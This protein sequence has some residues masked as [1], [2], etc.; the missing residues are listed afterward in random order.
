MMYRVTLP[1]EPTTQISTPINSVRT[2]ECMVRVCGEEFL[3]TYRVAVLGNGW[4]VHRP[5]A[6][7]NRAASRGNG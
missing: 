4:P 2:A 7:R 1:V 3:E 5:T 6:V